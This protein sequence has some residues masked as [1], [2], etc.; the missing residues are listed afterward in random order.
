M[1][2]LVLVIAIAIILGSCGSSDIGELIG[3][4]NRPQDWQ[5]PLPYGMAY[6]PAGS[7]NMGPADQDVPYS[8]I[9]KSRT[10]TVGAFYM[11]ETEIT[12]NE[13]RQFVYW[14]RDSLAHVILGKN[15][16]DPDAHYIKADRKGNQFDPLTNPRTYV[17]DFYFI[18]WKTE[19]DWLGKEDPAN[20]DALEEMYLPEHERFHFI[21]ELDT[22]KLIYD[23]YWIDLKKAADKNNRY[24]YAR[25]QE[26][27]QF[28]T[29]RLD[30]LGYPKANGIYDRRSFVVHDQVQVYPDT[31]CWIHDFTYS[32]NEP[33]TKMYFWHPAY[34]NYPVVGVNWK[35]ARAFCVWRTDL[36]NGYLAHNG[37]AF[38]NDFRLPT[39]GEWEWAAR[40]GLDLNSY[41]NGGPYLKDITGC[42][43]AN[44]KNMRG[45]YV[46]DGAI[47]TCVVGHYM[48]NDY[49]LYDMSGNVSEWTNNAYDESMIDFG[50]DMNI[51]YTYNAKESDQDVLKRK[52]IR[53]GSWKDIGY[54]LQIGTRS[55]EYQDTS[56]CYIGFRCVQSYLGNS[57][58]PN[59]KS[60]NYYQ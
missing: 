36:L 53:G 45:N 3:V 33:M 22:R 6:I 55:Y 4:Q 10:I 60:S 34:D 57:Q 15:G 58:N 38:Y 23:F 12:N 21:K 52:T 8:M 19:I 7:Y 2:N 47:N 31:L 5:Q 49:G 24:S 44:F 25:I 43:I 40:G 28:E 54:F 37:E 1:K 51:D 59:L 32:Y 46:D 30:T 41:P 20:K 35:Q 18:N 13:Y 26:N 29:Y 39:E 17:K 27:S 56:K 48:P 50:H 14:V 42:Y 9:S 11:D 16:S